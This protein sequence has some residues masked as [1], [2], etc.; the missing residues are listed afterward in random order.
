MKGRQADTGIIPTKPTPTASFQAHYQQRHHHSTHVRTHILLR[1]LL[2]LLQAQQL[3]PAVRAVDVEG[4]R[5]RAGRRSRHLLH[6]LHLRLLICCWRAVVVWSDVGECGG[7]RAPSICDTGVWGR[8]GVACTPAS[9]RSALQPEHQKC[10]IHFLRAPCCGPS[11]P[12]APRRPPQRRPHPMTLPQQH[13][14]R[15]VHT[16]PARPAG[17]CLR[18]SARSRSA[19]SGVMLPRLPVCRLGCDVDIVGYPVTHLTSEVGWSRQQWRLITI[20]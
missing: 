5:R 17:C 12:W 9:K 10:I 16:A 7:N 4:R 13:P 14:S 11:P 18:S 6:L 1:L 20:N 8:G 19:P 15:P 3:R 2:D